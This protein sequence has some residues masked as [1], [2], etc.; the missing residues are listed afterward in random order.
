MPLP[1]V[2]FQFLIGRLGTQVSQNLLVVRQ[3]FQFLIG[4]LGTLIVREKGGLGGWFQFLIGRLG[5][6]QTPSGRRDPGRFN[7]S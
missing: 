2:L 4:R 1:D 3:R 5:T 7:S 6:G